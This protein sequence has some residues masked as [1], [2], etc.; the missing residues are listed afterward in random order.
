M[1]NV[2]GFGGVVAGY[3]RAVWSIKARGFAVP[4]DL[5]RVNVRCKKRLAARR[6]VR[7]AF[8][9]YLMT[10]NGPAVWRDRATMRVEV[11]GADAS[12]GRQLV[13]GLRIGFRDAGCGCFLDAVEWLPAGAVKRYEF[14]DG[15]EVCAAEMIVKR[16]GE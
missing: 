10:D 7:G 5:M 9:D 1:S 2:C 14:S 3:V 6:R 4:V 15:A 12:A 8:A 11:V 16:G 13:G